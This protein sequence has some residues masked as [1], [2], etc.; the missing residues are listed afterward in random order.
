M[1]SPRMVN[2]SNEPIPQ[3]ESPLQSLVYSWAIAAKRMILPSLV[4]IIVV[5]LGKAGF[6][7]D[8]VKELANL[9]GEAIVLLVTMS[10]HRIDWAKY[11]KNVEAKVGGKK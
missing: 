5:W 10:A 6:A 4:S 11:L 7:G 3:E 9:L 8:Q 2:M 1:T